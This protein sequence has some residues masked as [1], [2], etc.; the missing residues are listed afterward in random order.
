MRLDHLAQRLGS[1]GMLAEP[2]SSEE[3]QGFRLTK[4]RALVALG[5]EIFGRG[6]KELGHAQ[7]RSRIRPLDSL[8]NLK[9]SLIRPRLGPNRVQAA[10]ASFGENA[11]HR[12][13]FIQP[14]GQAAPDE[15]ATREDCR[16]ELARGL[17]RQDELGMRHRLFEGL[18]QGV[19][20]G[21]V[22][23]MG[24][25]DQHRFVPSDQWTSSEKVQDRDGARL[26]IIGGSSGDG[27]VANHV[28]PPRRSDQ[29]KVD[30]VA[31]L[32]PATRFALPT[33]PARLRIEAQSKVGQMPREI[34]RSAALWPKQEDRA[35][36]IPAPK[37]GIDKVKSRT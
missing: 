7:G 22:H 25:V 20:G 3:P 4:A 33:R 24:V 5:R 21:E 6:S 26:V 37:N 28:L 10:G 9:E 17:G 16:S 29:L 13:R 31:V 18:Q 14:L 19:A 2:I 23:A 12:G 1:V 32:E 15:K 27:A 8:Q 35:G 11:L 30:G 36:Q 34:Q